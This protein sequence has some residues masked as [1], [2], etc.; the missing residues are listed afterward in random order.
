[1]NLFVRFLFDKI[2]FS[3]RQ[4]I[5]WLLFPRLKLLKV[6]YSTEM[7]HFITEKFGSSSVRVRFDEIEKFE[8]RSFTT[9]DDK[10]SAMTLDVTKIQ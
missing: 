10:Q 7:Y 1:M 3:K 2:V 9:I 5:F 8:V 4:I 6:V